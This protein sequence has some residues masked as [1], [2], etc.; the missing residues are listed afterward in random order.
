M[1]LTTLL[2]VYSTFVFRIT[3]QKVN[4]GEKENFLM[5]NVKKML[6]LAILLLVYSN[7]CLMY[8]KPKGK[9][10]WERKKF[11]IKSHLKVKL[12]TFTLLILLRTMFL[13]WTL[14]SFL[15]IWLRRRAFPCPHLHHE[16]HLLE[17]SR[18]LQ[19]LDSPSLKGSNKWHFA[20]FYFSLWD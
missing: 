18:H 17:L 3:S 19:R 12:E 9:F 15:F 7:F 11:N 13:W 20:Q 5:L 14:T 8:N 16:S 4:L 1:T 2:L 10:G 6:W